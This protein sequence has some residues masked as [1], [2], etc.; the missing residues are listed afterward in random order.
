VPKINLKDK[1]DANFLNVIKNKRNSN[2]NSGAESRTNSR[3]DSRPNS[4][5]NSSRMSFAY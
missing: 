1:M 4:R 2:L 5:P 3:T